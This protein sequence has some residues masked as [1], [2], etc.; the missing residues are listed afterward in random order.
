MQ[1]KL[2][3]RKVNLETRFN[4][5]TKQIEDLKTEQ[6]ILKGE[7]RLCEELLAEVTV[8]VIEPEIIKPVATRSAKK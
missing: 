1:E 6:T 2:E 7:Y 8:E 5:I 4:D 3:D